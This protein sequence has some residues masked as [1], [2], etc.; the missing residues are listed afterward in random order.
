VGGEF[1]IVDAVSRH[2]S[3]PASGDF[4]DK[5]SEIR[6]IIFLI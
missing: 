6:V 1:N 2:E 4:S 3:R 5:L